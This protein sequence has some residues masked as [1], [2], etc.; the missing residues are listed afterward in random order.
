MAV[1]APT[2]FGVSS[3]A[4]DDW[5]VLSPCLTSGLQFPML[6][7]DQAAEE[8][9]VWRQRAE[10]SAAQLQQVQVQLA[11]SDGLVSQQASVIQQLEQQLL[12]ADSSGGPGGEQRLR[13]LEAE[14]ASLRQAVR[15]AQRQAGSAKVGGSNGDGSSPAEVQLAELR[16]QVA[17]LQAQLCA[18]EEQHQ[19]QMRMMQHE[20]QRLRTEEG[21][22]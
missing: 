15:E 22:R 3:R 2:P 17:R 1:V 8:Q 20:H 14:N 13:Q 4:V 6:Q 10:A 11:D 18:K 5:G 21:I 19:R 9:A 16:G 12:Q 7:L